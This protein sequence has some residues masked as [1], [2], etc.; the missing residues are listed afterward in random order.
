MAQNLENIGVET[1]I[2]KDKSNDE[3]SVQSSEMVMKFIMNG[4]IDKK[5]YDLHFDFGNKRNNEL[6]NNYEE[7]EKFHNK[8]KKALS[9]KKEV[10]MSK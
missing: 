10:I 3:K 4:M 2:E 7:Q 1:A 8:L 5:K 9:H 6:L